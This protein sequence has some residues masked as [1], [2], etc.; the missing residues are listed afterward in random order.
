[1][2]GKTLH[3]QS[4]AVTVGQ[5]LAAAGL[6]LQNS[7][8]SIPTEDQPIPASRVIQIVRVN[9]EVVLEQKALPF[10]TETVSS[11][12]VNIDQHQVLQPGQPGL[13]V[14]RVRVRYEDGKEVSRR[15]E[16]DWIV[17]LPVKQK[18][19]VGTHI[20]VQ[21]LD[22][23]SGVIEYYRSMTVYATS[24]SPCNSD[25]NRC[26]PSTSNGMHVQRGVIGV[27]R[28]WYNLLVGQRVYVPGYGTAVIADIGAGI[29]GKQWIDLG[30]S[31]SD[32]EDWHQNVTLYFLTPIPPNP[33]WNLP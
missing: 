2:D 30:F 33:Q 22:T 21:K 26:Y 12:Q 5:A 14:S 4:A 24:Y 7:D 19:A 29:P 20:P 13:Q 25:A 11:D 8:V 28:Q 6:S 10:E 3:I 1:M 9:E 15:V 31:D 27:T 16:S 18:V 32:Y 23:P 17:L